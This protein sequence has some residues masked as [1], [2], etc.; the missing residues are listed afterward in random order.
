MQGVH[1][2]K[3][4]TQTTIDFELYEID[5]VDFKTN[6]AHAAGDSK[7]MKDEGD[8][9][10]T[11]NGFTDEGQGYS[12]VLTATE[13]QAARIVL[14]IVDQSTKV[15]LDKSVVIETYGNASAMHILSSRFED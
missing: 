8:E 15:W 4:G 5:G 14:Y 12:I 7:I 2:R 13:M 3:Y 9:A 1:L 10:N 11:T 6:A